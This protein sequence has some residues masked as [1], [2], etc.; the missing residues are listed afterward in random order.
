MAASMQPANAER[1]SG[2]IGAKWFASKSG[3]HVW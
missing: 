1:W 2:G 3:N